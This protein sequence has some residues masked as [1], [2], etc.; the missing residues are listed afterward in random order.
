MFAELEE[1]N[2]YPSVVGLFLFEA[3]VAAVDSFFNIFMKL[4][5]NKTTNGDLSYILKVKW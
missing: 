1:A 2:Q 3:F 5:Y 4:N